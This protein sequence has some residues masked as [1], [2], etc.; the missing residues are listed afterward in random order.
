MT[1]YAAKSFFLS[2]ILTTMIFSPIATWGCVMN[3]DLTDNMERMVV[4]L[5]YLGI[6]DKPIPSLLFSVRVVPEAL[7][8]L[9]R[10][11][12]LHANDEYGITNIVIASQRLQKLV[13]L[14][15]RRAGNV[16]DDSTPSVLGIALIVTGQQGCREFQLASADAAIFFNQLHEA[17]SSDKEA[18]TQFDWW[19]AR[20]NL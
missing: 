17:L 14:V 7:E 3:Q 6:Q 20:T 11:Q 12:L 8:M 15:E 5:T 13:E 18:V 9:K 4:K 1:Q 19:R 10:H 2:L 16:A